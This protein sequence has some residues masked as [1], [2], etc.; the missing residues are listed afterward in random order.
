MGG[1]ACE[2]CLGLGP[3]TRVPDGCSVPV[4][5]AYWPSWSVPAEQSQFLVQGFRTLSDSILP[6]IW[7]RQHVARLHIQPV[8]LRL[9]VSHHQLSVQLRLHA[10]APVWSNHRFLHHQVAKQAN[11]HC[12]VWKDE[13]YQLY[14]SEHHWLNDV[15]QL[16]IGPLQ[17]YG[18]Y[19]EQPCWGCLVRATAVLLPLVD[20]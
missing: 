20:V 17:I 14:L 1:T 3:W 9:A 2:S 16:G 5:N 8:A 15:L 13:P 6:T 19:R 4:W 10:L 12:P 7:H 18:H 11:V